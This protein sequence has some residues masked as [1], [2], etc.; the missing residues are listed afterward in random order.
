MFLFDVLGPQP[1]DGPLNST[2]LPEVKRRQSVGKRSG[3]LNIRCFF[4]YWLSWKRQC[5]SRTLQAMQ[6]TW[7]E[8]SMLSHYKA[9]IHTRNLVTPHHR[10]QH[11]PNLE[12]CEQNRC[13]EQ[14][15]LK[16]MKWKDLCAMWTN[17]EST[18]LECLQDTHSGRC[19]L[20]R[21]WNHT[22]NWFKMGHFTLIRQRVDW[23]PM[24]IAWHKALLFALRHVNVLPLIAPNAK[25]VLNVSANTMWNLVPAVWIKQ[26]FTAEKQ[27][28]KETENE[29]F[30][31]LP[32]HWWICWQTSTKNYHVHPAHARKMGKKLWDLGKDKI[33]KHGLNKWSAMKQQLNNWS[34]MKQQMIEHSST[35]V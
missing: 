28:V 16:T 5:S 26:A 17:V 4:H 35:C 9:S 25:N 15:I 22:K 19:V 20:A 12:C 34:E 33:N 23:V 29:W 24:I 18:N 21:N 27:T 13:Y 1:Q 6:M 3:S 32:S 14:K 11:F 2:T 10:S 31:S 8:T 7:L 30:F